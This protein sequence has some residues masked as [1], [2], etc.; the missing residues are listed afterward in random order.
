MIH[1]Y[2]ELH[3]KVSPLKGVVKVSQRQ[4]SSTRNE[5][6]FLPFDGYVENFIDDIDLRIVSKQLE[7]ESY[8]TD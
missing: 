3:N 1:G 2:F 7:K 4:H 8:A 5:H 6:P